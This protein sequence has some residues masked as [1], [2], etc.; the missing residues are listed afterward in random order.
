[1]SFGAINEDDYILANKSIIG[2]MLIQHRT[3]I[4]QMLMARF[5]NKRYDYVLEEELE[6]RYKV[7]SRLLLNFNSKIIQG[8]ATEDEKYAAKAASM[9][10]GIWTGIGMLLMAMSAGFDDDDKKEAWYKFSNLVG[11]RI[12]AELGFFVPLN[13]SAQS[14]ILLHPAA[15]ISLIDDYGRLTKNIWKEVTGDEKEQKS[16]KPLKSLGKVVPYIGQLQRFIDEMFNINLSNEE[17]K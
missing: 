12:F 3:W 15:S 17:K 4:P 10:L 5:A 9:E 14:Q 13:V 2:R 16:A 11:Q 6:G 7:L 1:M 8:T